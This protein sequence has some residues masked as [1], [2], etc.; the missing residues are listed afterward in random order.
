MIPPYIVRTYFGAGPALRAV[1]FHSSCEEEQV[2]DVTNTALQVLMQPVYW[3]DPT[4]WDVLQ[5]FRANPAAIDL[6]G[7]QAPYM[8][9]WLQEAQTLD[10]SPWGDKYVELVIS[11]ESEF[12]S[13]NNEV[14]TPVAYSVQAKVFT[15]GPAGPSF[16]NGL[17]GVHHTA[18]LRAP[19]RFEGIV[20][21]VEGDFEAERFGNLLRAFKHPRPRLIEL[22]IGVVKS[23]CP[24]PG[25]AIS[26]ES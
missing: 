17:Y 4:L 23:F 16:I 14:V 18:L 6:L 13:S 26:S 20:H 10:V 11:A 19:I 21:E 25:A 24:A 5:L 22:L 15:H 7:E 2:K 12:S 9:R 1:Y 8:R 3:E